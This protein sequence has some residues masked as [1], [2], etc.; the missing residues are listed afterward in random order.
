MKYIVYGAGQNAVATIHFIGPQ[1]VECLCDSY[2]F[3]GDILDKRI[4][5][6]DEMTAMYQTGEYIV[7]ISPQD[8]KVVQEISKTLLSRKISRFFPFIARNDL[9]MDDCL[10]LYSI[11]RKW[12]SMSYTDV[13]A[14]YQVEKYKHIAIAGGN[15]YLKYLISEIAMQCG[16]FTVDY[17]I[18]TDSIMGVPSE[19]LEGIEQ[20]IDCLIINEHRTD[21]DI[22]QKILDD[23]KFD[24]I[25]IFDITDFI[26]QYHHPELGK[27]KNIYKG[28]RCFI[29]GN[30]PSLSMKD[31]DM[32]ADNGEI[33]FG[34]NK[35]YLAF[36]KTKWRPDYLCVSDPLMLSACNPFIKK[37]KY[38]GVFYT[39]EFHWTS[40]RR[41]EGVNYLHHILEDY[42]TANGPQFSDDITR[43]VYEGF[44]VVYDICLQVASYM[45]FSEIYLVGVDHSF[46]ENVTDL[47]N[48]FSEKY[49]SEEDRKLYRKMNLLNGQK[50][51]ITAAYE[52]AESYSRKHG[53]HIYNATRGGELEVFE[54]VDLDSLFS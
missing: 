1:R 30:G 46:S 21:S 33:C 37:N 16:T 49:Y 24:V 7:V 26:R 2:H 34:V 8:S 27:F 17:L 41:E 10:P 36:D 43:G 18:D 44:S 51:K 31:L 5:S 25:N 45:G 52:K 40:N 23:R 35:I 13:L 42:S 38:K 39:D 15:K 48:H 19:S 20:N 9:N 32:L 22:F 28:K 50:E 53:F 6:L 29:I 54:R 12:Q 4:I 11:Y 14:H 47:G 3:G